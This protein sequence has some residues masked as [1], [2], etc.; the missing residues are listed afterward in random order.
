MTVSAGGLR[1]SSEV[2]LRSPAFSSASW[3]PL[4]RHI[5]TSRSRVLVAWLQ[6]GD[7]PL[8]KPPGAVP[9]AGREGQVTTRAAQRRPCLCGGF[10]PTCR[11]GNR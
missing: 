3:A 1:A 10:Y 9:G 8:H 2:T 7:L 5:I 6:V 4:F 11:G